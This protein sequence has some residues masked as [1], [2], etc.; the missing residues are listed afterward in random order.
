MHLPVSSIGE[1]AETKLKKN[2]F[3]SHHKP[4]TV[5]ETIDLDD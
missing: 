1:I 2:P 3:F 4:M 5:F